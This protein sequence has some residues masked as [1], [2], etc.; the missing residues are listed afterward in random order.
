MGIH[1]TRTLDKF[2]CCPTQVCVGNT[3]T[4]KSF[5]ASMA[6]DVIAR[7]GSEKLKSSK[8]SAAALRSKVFTRQNLTYLVHDPE[9]PLTL[10]VLSEDT[11]DG[12]GSSNCHET[13]LPRSSGII[14]CNDDY[15]AAFR[16][17]EE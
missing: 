9:E 2:G 16:A 10:K 11:F 14:T 12:K 1:Y 17:L 8:I 4:G 5:C 6:E 3:G 7:N 13:V 15:L